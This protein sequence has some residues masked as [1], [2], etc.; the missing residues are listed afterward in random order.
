M[1]TRHS[2]SGF[3]LAELLIALGILGVIAT[4]TIPKVLVSNQT[5][6]YK[7]KTKEAISMISGAFQAYKHQN[8]VDE[9]TGIED[10]TPYMNYVSLVPSG[11]QLDATPGGGTTLKNC[12][13]TFAGTF[14]CVILHNGVTI[15]YR[16]V[17]GQFGTS[18][19]TSAHRVVWFEVDPNGHQT[20]NAP[21]E[22][23]ANFYLAQNGR[24]T[25]NDGVLANSSSSCCNYDPDPGTMPSW[26]SW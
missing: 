7:A 6:S 17:N 20:N 3:T 4:F 24:I 25:D 1:Q 13:A 8:T 19:A 16:A 10:L 9:N 15:R 21:Q 26:F 14:P 23:T 12:N 2:L 18:G 11:A 5:S 22:M